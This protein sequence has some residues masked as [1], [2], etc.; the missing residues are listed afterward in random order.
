MIVNHKRNAEQPECDQYR[1]E[2]EVRYI[3]SLQNTMV[4]KGMLDN[5]EKKRGKASAN[6]LRE[7]VRAEL[8]S[9]RGRRY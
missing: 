2:C 1:H 8:M 6:K 3:A 7:D 5:I 4:M 9:R